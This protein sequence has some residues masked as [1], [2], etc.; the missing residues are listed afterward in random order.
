MEKF[1]LN[2]V[3][4]ITSLEEFVAHEVRNKKKAK[5]RKG[6]RVKA[7]KKSSEKI[8]KSGLKKAVRKV[9]KSGSKKVVKES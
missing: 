5:L 8:K 7:K 4:L 3:L 9:K 1:L 6:S 2:A